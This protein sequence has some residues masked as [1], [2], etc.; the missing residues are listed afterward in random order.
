VVGVDGSS[1]VV[2]EANFVNGYDEDQR[3]IP[4]TQGVM[5]FIYTS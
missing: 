1:F 5:G 4:N 3:Y 2:D